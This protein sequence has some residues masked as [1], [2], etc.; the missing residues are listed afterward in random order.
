M[1]DGHPDPLKCKEAIA[2]AQVTD[3][4]LVPGI[5]EFMGA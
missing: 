1:A 3:D 2:G 5:Y 4:G